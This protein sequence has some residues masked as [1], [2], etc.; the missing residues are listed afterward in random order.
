MAR[1]IEQEEGNPVS[2]ESPNRIAP[3]T[4]ASP[5]LPT[6]KFLVVD[7]LHDHTLA[8]APTNCVTR[9]L[10]P[11]AI[12]REASLPHSHDSH[13]LFHD[14]RSLSHDSHS[15]SHRAPLTRATPTRTPSPNYTH[16]HHSPSPSP[17]I[18]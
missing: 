18:E 13:S 3:L 14:S 1:S 4:I 8:P 15:L 16:S 9:S 11:G 17:T 10:Q 2:I 7:N 5:R 6:P 12:P